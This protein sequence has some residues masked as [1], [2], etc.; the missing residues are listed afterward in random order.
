[1]IRTRRDLHR[2]AETGWLEYRT[3]ALLIKKLKEHGIP[4]KYGKEIINKDYLWAYP[5]ESVRKSAIDRAL[6]E[7]TDPEIIEKM[8]GFTERRDLSSHSALISTV[9]MSPRAPM[10][11]ASL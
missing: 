6:A 4:V 9:T 10:R 1:M 11:T 5:S 3:T 2:H 8:D 7:G